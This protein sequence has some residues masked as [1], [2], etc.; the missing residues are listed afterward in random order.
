MLLLHHNTI[1]EDRYRKV[2][3]TILYQN[4]TNY[5][6]VLVDDGSNDETYTQSK[7]FMNNNN[8]N[9]QKI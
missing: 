2:L 4:Y 8:K 1:L 7:L 3:Q 9:N 6:I 5:H